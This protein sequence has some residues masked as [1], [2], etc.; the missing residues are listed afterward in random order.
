MPV[1]VNRECCWA[2]ATLKYLVLTLATLVG[3]QSESSTTPNVEETVI[4]MPCELNVNHE[5]Q[6]PLGTS[7]PG[8]P[9]QPVQKLGAL[10][11]SIS[12]T[13]ELQKFLRI[14]DF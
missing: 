12:R 9:C 13:R 10:R 2:Q 7:G 1:P 5:I 8:G 4:P 11:H 6:G 3:K 14:S